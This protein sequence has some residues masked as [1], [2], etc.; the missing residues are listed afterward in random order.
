MKEMGASKGGGS[1]EGFQMRCCPSK[2]SLK[3]Q[4][5]NLRSE[6]KVEDQKGGGKCLL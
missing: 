1:E 4:P 2:G 6:D 3:A 5:H